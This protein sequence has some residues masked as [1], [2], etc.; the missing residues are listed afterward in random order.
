MSAKEQYRKEQNE[1]LALPPK[2]IL[3]SEEGEEWY[4]RRADQIAADY[5]KSVGKV[6]DSPGDD[7]FFCGRCGWSHISTYPHSH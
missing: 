3:E 1:L 7:Y 4:N 5:L 2:G 6:D